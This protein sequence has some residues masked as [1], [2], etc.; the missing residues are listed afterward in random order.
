M[1][2]YVHE[3]GCFLLETDQFATGLRGCWRVQAHS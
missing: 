3:I 1:A 2:V